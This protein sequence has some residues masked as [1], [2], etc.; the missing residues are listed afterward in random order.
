MQSEQRFSRAVV[1]ILD[2]LGIGELPDAA[3]FGDAGAAT[4]QHIAEAVPGFSLPN[5]ERMGLG[6]IAPIVG[7]P[8]AQ[9]P[10]GYGG[11]MAERSVG[12]DTT[13]GHWELAGLV[14]KEA[15]S[16][17]PHGFPPEI[18][19][20]FVAR[21]GRGILG[22]KTASGTQILDELGE[23]HLRTGKW[24][25]YTSADSVF[26][27]AAHEQKIPL[28][29]LYQACRQAR[30]LLDPYRVGRV[31]ARPF[32]GQPG[33]FERTYNRH[34]FSFLPDG[35]TVLDALVAQG[36][37]VT[38][39]G[40]I[41]DIFAGVGIS[42]SLPTHGNADGMAQTEALIDKGV[43]GLIFT[44]LVDFD[45]NYG[46]R[47]DPQGYARALEGFDRWLPSLLLKLGPQDLLIVTADHGCDPTYLAHTDHTREYVPVLVFSPR[48]SRGGDLGVRSSFADVAATLAAALG[49]PWNGPGTS[50]LP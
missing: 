48:F 43:E 16:L 47:R 34:D 9:N 25:L 10:S 39:V 4:L 2:S 5:L 35:P 28:E 8:P 3:A 26:Q 17:F 22:N 21:T 15:F 18:V 11:K 29:E 46:H 6:R 50:L 44:N 31:I 24:I 40:K 45:M 38:G 12:K 42:R 49:V 32:V 41:P 13:T 27:L 23:E 30:A 36:I 37:E 20:P 19:E 14:V 1:V 7:V 33:A